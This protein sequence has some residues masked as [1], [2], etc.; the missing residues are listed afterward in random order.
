MIKI[1]LLPPEKRKK[2]RK[3]QA[4]QKKSKLPALAGFKFSFRFDV[5]TVMPAAA[6]ALA[7]LVIGGSFFWLGYK[8]KSMK[9]RRDTMRVELNRLNQVILHIDDLKARTKKVRDRME[10]ILAV[11]RNRFLWPRILDD[12]S[13]ALPRYTWLDN[14]SE[15]TPFPQLTVRIEG[16]TMS[17]ILLSELIANLEQSAM[18]DR[19]KLISSTEQKHGS[20]ATKFF[21]LEA[22]CALNE[23][24]DSAQVA[25]K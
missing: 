15:V 19:I 6:A 11:D 4:A 24:A 9:E 14:I 18:L 10:V 8:E 2:I 7:L 23:P 21:V 12:V 13:G 16:N 22:E 5:L 25:A 17:N 20:Y 3:V 1:N